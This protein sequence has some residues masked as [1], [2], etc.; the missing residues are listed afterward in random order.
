MAASSTA[1]K[2]LFPMENEN[3]NAT[4]TEESALPSKDANLAAVEEV[5]LPKLTASEFWEYNRLAEHMD[6]FVSTLKMIPALDHIS[7]G[8]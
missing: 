8:T 5:K 7:S 1:G 3:E 2:P 6:S 4:C